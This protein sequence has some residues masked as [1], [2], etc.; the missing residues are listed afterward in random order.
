MIRVLPHYPTMGE[1]YAVN[2]NAEDRLDAHWGAYFG[3]PHV[4]TTEDRHGGVQCCKYTTDSPTNG[5]GAVVWQQRAIR[6]GRFKVSAWIK[7]PAGFPVNV[8]IRAMP[9]GHEAGS[10]VVNGTGSW[11]YVESLVADYTNWVNGP[12][13]PST[14]FYFKPAPAIGSVLYVDDVTITQVP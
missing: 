1:N 9:T 5:Q 11:Q 7:A 10:V 3:C 12:T 4:M 14:N 2:A 6:A 8:G 13:M